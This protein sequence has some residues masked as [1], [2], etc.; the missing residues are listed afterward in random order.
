MFDKIVGND[1]IKETLIKSVKLNKTSHSYLFTGIEGIGKKMIAREFA[2]ILMCLSENKYCNN[3]KSCIEFDTNNNP[4]FF[5]IEPEG[6]SI[7]IEQIRN[8]QRK[9]AEKPII[10]NKKIF[11]IDD[12]DKMTVEAQNCL[13][14]TL[15][16]PPNYITIILITSNENNLLATIKSRCTIIHFNKISNDNLKNY[17][18]SEFQ[19]E[20]ITTDIIDIADGSIGRLIK[21]KDKNEIY[22]SINLIVK[23]IKNKES[24]LDIINNADILYKGKEEIFEILDYMNIVF[25]KSQNSKL[26]NCISIVEQTKNRL[27]SNA[28]YDMSIDNM[29]FNI[30]GEVNEKNSRS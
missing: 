19:G 3:C 6:N 21:L 30:W 5:Y 24:I 4:D 9:V 11:I 17:I 12:A 28:N 1:S 18:K 15:E 25:L 20:K 14:K 8:A 29:L 2:K 26:I 22:S 27:K 13:L 23:Q 16:E 10:S 7:K